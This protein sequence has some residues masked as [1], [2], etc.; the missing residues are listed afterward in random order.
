M[1][2]D[3]VT[4]PSFTTTALVFGGVLNSLGSA[5]DFFDKL[6]ISWFPLAFVN[7]NN[8]TF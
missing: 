2:F 4:L 6:V 8:S 1:S 7:L 5:N 3:A